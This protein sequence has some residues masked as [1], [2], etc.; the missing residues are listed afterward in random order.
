MSRRVAWTLTGIVAVLVI[1]GVITAIIGGESLIPTKPI[2]DGQRE[3]HR[4]QAVG[5]Y[6]FG[7][8]ALI[9]LVWSSH[10]ARPLVWAALVISIAVAAGLWQNIEFNSRAGVTWAIATTAVVSFVATVWAQI[11]KG[12]DDNRKLTKYV[13]RNALTA[14]FSLTYLVTV[15]LVVFYRGDSAADRL[16]AI[17]DTMLQSYTFLMTVVVGFYFGGAALE[18]SAEF[19]AAAKREA[20]VEE[21]RRIADD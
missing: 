3:V 20:T 18:K 13:M 11:G 19:K 7:G 8:L 2:V 1:V 9:A 4:E 5:I 21:I 17:T 15:A 16:P 14:S 10:V 12:D 6:V